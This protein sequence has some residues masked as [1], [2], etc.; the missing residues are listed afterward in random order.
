MTSELAA[1]LPEDLTPAERERRQRASAPTLRDL[2]AVASRLAPVV[3][4][5]PR[6][7]PLTT[8]SPAKAA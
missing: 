4:E 6:A 7:T 3:S 5:G 1:P 2:A 8:S